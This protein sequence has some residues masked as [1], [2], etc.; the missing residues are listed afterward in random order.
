MKK[1]L[2]VS[3]LLFIILLF[4]ACTVTYVEPKPQPPI[5]MYNGYFLRY[6]PIPYNLPYYTAP[7]YPP[8]QHH[9]VKRPRR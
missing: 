6:Y 7:I 9:E 5:M 3:S 2:K 8:K 1:I 4:S